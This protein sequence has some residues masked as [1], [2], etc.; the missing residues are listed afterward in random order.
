MAREQAKDAKDAK[1][2]NGAK[3]PDKRQTP[4][5]VFA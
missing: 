1:D 4:H 2:A 3:G 5:Q